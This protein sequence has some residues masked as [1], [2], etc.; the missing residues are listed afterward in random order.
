MDVS[1]I[2][3]FW[4]GAGGKGMSEAPG[5]GGGFFIE[6]PRRGVSRRG[7]GREG[8]QGVCGEVENLG[9]GG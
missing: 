5:G 6:N 2:F 9:G 4:L 1:E 3:I 7:R 8:R